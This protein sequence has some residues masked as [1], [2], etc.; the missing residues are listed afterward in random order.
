MRLTVP[1]P[2]KIGLVVLGTTGLYTYIGQLVPQ[3]EVLPPPA[4]TAIS[5]EAT[6]E[7]LTAR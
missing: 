6:P 3:K 1:T 2:L 4:E 7:Q 5:A